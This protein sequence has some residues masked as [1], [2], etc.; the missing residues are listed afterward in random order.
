MGWCRFTVMIFTATFR[1]VGDS[2]IVA[3]GGGGGD[4]AA[5]DDIT[6]VL[7]YSVVYLVY[8]TKLAMR[9]VCVYRD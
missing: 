5:C 9:A 1:T 2:I 6:I 4:R 3:G 8:S 7:P